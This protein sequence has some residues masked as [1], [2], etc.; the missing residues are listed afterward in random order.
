MELNNKYELNI[1]SWPIFGNEEIQNLSEVVKSGFWAG[2]RAKFLKEAVKDFLELQNAKF[3]IPLA[4]GTVTIESALKALNIGKNDEVI[5]PAMTFYSTISAVLRVNAN[6]IIVDIDSDTLCISIDDIIK[7]ISKNTKAI[8]P[9]HLSGAMCNMSRLKEIADKYNIAIIE[10]CAHAHGSYW[11]GKGAGT[12][13]TFGSFSFQHSKLI[14]SGE[15]GF[16]ISTNQKYLNKAWNYSNCGRSAAGSTYEHSIVGTNNRMSDFQ[17][18]VLS[19]QIKRYKIQQ[20]TRENN[21]EYMTSVL[22]KIPGIKTQKYDEKMDRKAYY[23]FII[24]IDPQVYGEN[25]INKIFNEFNKLNI[26]TSLPYPPLSEL[27]VFKNAKS[28]KDLEDLKIKVLD[29]SNSK[30]LFNNSIWLHHR[31]LL[32]NRKTI[33]NFL[34]IFINLLEEK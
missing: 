20:F 30:F 28:S 9:V 27:E 3:G 24:I 19:A 2:S 4:N 21:A 6:P 34:E 16:L 33:D 13:G 18:A 12:I 25:M 7:A 8:I 5:V 31:L 11:K 23:N 32:S 14:S 17:A 26:P 29:I 1:S 10:D 22:S 15:G